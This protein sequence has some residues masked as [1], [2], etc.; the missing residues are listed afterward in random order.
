MTVDYHSFPTRTT[1][2]RP[3]LGFGTAHAGPKWSA[4]VRALRAA[5]SAAQVNAPYR[6]KPTGD[7]IAEAVIDHIDQLNARDRVVLAAI[8]GILF[9]KTNGNS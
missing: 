1:Q 6:S 5:I 2:V 4:A 8:L 3:L 7:M 9:R